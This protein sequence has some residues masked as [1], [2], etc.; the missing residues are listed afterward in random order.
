MI[1]YS[2]RYYLDKIFDALISDHGAEPAYAMFRVLLWE[3]RK[4]EEKEGKEGEEEKK[5]RK[6]RREKKEEKR[7]KRKERKGKE[8]KE[9]IRRRRGE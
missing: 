4:E 8:G 7:K 5:K 3:E 1:M 2:R 9:E 6:E